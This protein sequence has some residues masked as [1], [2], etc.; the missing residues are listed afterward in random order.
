MSASRFWLIFLASLC[1]AFVWKAAVAHQE[2]A[3]WNRFRAPNQ[4]AV[5][6]WDALFLE[7]RV[8]AKQ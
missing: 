8:E 2:A 7:L 6:W 5:T 3:A 1:F 4:P